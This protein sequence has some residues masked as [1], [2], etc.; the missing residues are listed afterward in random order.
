M[1]V[2]INI[3]VWRPECVGNG[4]LLLTGEVLPT[5]DVV[6]SLEWSVSGSPWHTCADSVDVPSTF[7]CWTHGASVLPGTDEY[8]EWVDQGTYYEAIVYRPVVYVTRSGAF[9]DEVAFGSVG[10]TD[11]S[12]SQDGDTIR[13]RPVD[14]A[15]PDESVSV[16]IM[17]SYE[18]GRAYS[19]TVRALSGSTYTTLL[20]EEFTWTLVTRDVSGHMMDVVAPSYIG[21]MQV[22]RDIMF[23]QGMM[24]A[25]AY[26]VFDDYMQQGYAATATW[27]I[28]IWESLLGLPSIAT[29]DTASRRAAIAEVVRNGRGLR[30]DFFAAVE[31]AIST[32]GVTVTD[33]YSNYRVD[34]RLPLSGTSSADADIRASAESVIS[35]LKPAGVEVIVGYSTFLADISQAG[36]P[37]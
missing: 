28:P 30:P 33:T 37:L 20:E 36:D 35:R 34:V 14:G 7:A 22:A 5:S 9:V 23:A 15:A 1:A 19:L 16:V 10:S 6:D 29:L 18:E 8:P 32:P 24:V 4:R 17:P 13:Y 26:S 21:Q 31:S 12:W 11:G 27:S 2:E 25:D 3:D